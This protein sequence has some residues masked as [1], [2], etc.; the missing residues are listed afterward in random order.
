MICSEDELGIGEDHSRIVVL[1]GD[2][3]IGTTAR[4]YY[5]I[6]TDVVYEIGLTPIN[7]RMRPTTWGN[8]KDVA[9]YLKVNHGHSGECRVT[10]FRP[11]NN[12]SLPVKVVENPEASPR[13]AGVTIK[14]ITVG[15]RLTGCATACCRSTCAPI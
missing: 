2:V 9:A 14:G 4:E 11:D 10:G 1:P 6:E 3:P 7:A 8:F 5:K 13:Y 12:S 15:N